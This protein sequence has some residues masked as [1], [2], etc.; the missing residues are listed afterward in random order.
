MRLGAGGRSSA[1]R[2]QCCYNQGCCS[3]YG[4]MVVV[5][6]VVM[7]TA[8]RA[9]K[10]WGRG[11]IVVLGARVGEIRVGRRE[12]ML[13]MVMTI[14]MKALMVVAVMVGKTGGRETWKRVTVVCVAFEVGR[15]VPEGD[16][17]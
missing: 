10:T 4:D 12:V 16:R 5:V 6:K 1:I 14:A 13:V 8:G 11:R 3:T 17:V 15:D 2:R 7:M 9:S